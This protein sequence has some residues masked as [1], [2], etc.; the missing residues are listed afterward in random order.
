MYLFFSFTDS[1][2]TVHKANKVAFDLGEDAQLEC[3]MQAYP[4]PKFQWTF[5]PNFVESGGAHYAINDTALPDDVYASVLTVRGVTEADYGRYI[6]KGT[7]SRGDHKTLITLQEKGRPEHPTN[8]R[9]INQGTEFIELAWDESFNGGFADTIFYVRAE[10]MSGERMSHDCQTLNPCT[11]QPLPQQ[12]A[13][14]L[15]VKASNIMGDSDFSDPLEAMTFVD[16]D[17]IPEPEEVYLEK[18]GNKLSFRVLP[19]NLMLQG[20][21]ETR[22]ADSDEWTKL[23]M[24]IPISSDSHDPGEVVLGEEVPEEVRI[25]FCSIF[26]ESS[27]GKYRAATKGELVYLHES[28]TDQS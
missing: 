18:A 26:V 9:V 8:L 21:V 5:G 10:T 24:L 23:D 17:S 1:P 11:I 15:Q 14:K 19:T 22:G 27:C 2:I 12:T 28:Y 25:K 13:F 7:N 6:C 20:Q 4:E 16:V 3:R